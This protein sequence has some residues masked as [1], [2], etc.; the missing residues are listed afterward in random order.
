MSKY[1]DHV[2]ELDYNDIEFPVMQN[3][4]NKIE[5]QN[6]INVNVFGYEEK[7]PFPIYLSKEESNKDVLNLLLITDNDKQHYVYI[8]NFNRFMHV[9]TK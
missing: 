1:K 8:K 6:S 5:K 2:D 3:Q 7:Q 9:P 4:Y